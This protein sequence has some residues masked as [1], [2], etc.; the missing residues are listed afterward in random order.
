MT[1]EKQEA[2][3]KNIAMFL[4]GVVV[5]LMVMWATYVRNAVTRDEMENYVNQRQGTLEQQVTDLNKN[6]VSLKEAVATLN[7]ELAARGKP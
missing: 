3:W 2:L 1:A 4:A 6:V 7:A 5:S